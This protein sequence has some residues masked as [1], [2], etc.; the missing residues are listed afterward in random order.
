MIIETQPRFVVLE[1]ETA[2]P[3]PT[4]VVES[5]PVDPPEPSP[6]P[7]QKAAGL[8]WRGLTVGVMASAGIFTLGLM[9]GVIE[10]PRRELGSTVLRAGSEPVEREPE[11]AE[12][13]VVPTDL[14]QGRLG[15]PYS[16]R[17]G[18]KDVDDWA[19]QIIE[20]SLPPGLTMNPKGQIA[21]TVTS[22]RGTPGVWQFKVYGSAPNGAGVTAPFQIRIE[23][24]R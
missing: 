12:P 5:L 17:L 24:E 15:Q 10:W 6:E 18:S 4:P 14:P 9:T 23:G 1:G 7:P 8:R 21:G 16:H 2:E 22:M 20:G 19:W 13:V 3:P 11:P